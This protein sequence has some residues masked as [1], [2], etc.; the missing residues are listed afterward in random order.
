MADFVTV[1]VWKFRVIN[2][3]KDLTTFQ[4]RGRSNFSFPG[5]SFRL[6]S[7]LLRILNVLPADMQSN[8]DS[9]NDGIKKHE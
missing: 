7:I 6:V 8:Q 3:E 4:L 5:A 2:C 9:L 1:C